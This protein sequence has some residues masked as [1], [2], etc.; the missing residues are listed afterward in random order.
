MIPN[1]NTSLGILILMQLLLSV[2]CYAQHEQMMKGKQVFEQNQCVACHGKD[3]TTPYNLS[4]R[5][6]SLSDEVLKEFIKDPAAFG[7]RQ[8]PAFRSILSDAD[9]DALIVYVRTLSKPDQKK[10]RRR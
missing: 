1:K 10:R 8:M 4:V 3:G 6:D 2:C 7:N 5:L 9:I